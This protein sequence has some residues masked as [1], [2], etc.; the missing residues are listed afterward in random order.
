MISIFLKLSLFE[1]YHKL[2]SKT[3]D[4][5]SNE[6]TSTISVI[7][8]SGISVISIMGFW[9]CGSL[10][11]GSPDSVSYIWFA[12]T[13]VETVSVFGSSLFFG[14]SFAN[15]FWIEIQFINTFFFVNSPNRESK[16]RRSL[17]NPLECI[18]ISQTI[19]IIMI[20]IFIFLTAAYWI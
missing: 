12:A 20:A 11:S 9:F 13:G 3:P 8:I 14:R 18:M 7:S 15:T 6:R 2:F 5:S 4:S 1:Q 19:L 17:L 10:A 16:Y